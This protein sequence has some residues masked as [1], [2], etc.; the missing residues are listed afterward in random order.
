MHASYEIRV[1]PPTRTNQTTRNLRKNFS[2]L[3]FVGKQFPLQSQRRIWNDA[4]NSSTPASAREPYC[5]SSLIELHTSHILVVPF[6]LLWRWKSLFLPSEFKV[7]WI[8]FPLRSC[9]KYLYR[10]NLSYCII[11]QYILAHCRSFHPITCFNTSKK[12]KHF[13][14]KNL[15]V[16]CYLLCSLKNWYLIEWRKPPDN[17]SYCTCTMYICMN[18]VWFFLCL[19]CVTLNDCCGIVRS[20]V[21]MYYIKFL[22]CHKRILSSVL[23]IFNAINPNRK[24]ERKEIKQ[25]LQKKQIHRQTNE[26]ASEQESKSSFAIV[27]KRTQ[28]FRW[29]AEILSKEKC[30]RVLHY[31]C[32]TQT[33]NNSI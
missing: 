32:S 28:L 7:V 14:I 19:S 4:I 13:K 21:V 22:F 17:V 31:C 16:I 30:K 12:K 24:K 1:P 10:W 5:M 11:N 33:C 29:K 15:Q 8:P 25:Q 3:S 2:L 18:V 9:V 23:E 6:L 27:D 26:Q 20:W